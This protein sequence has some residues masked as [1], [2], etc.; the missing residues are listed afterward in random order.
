MSGT[1]V[2][3]RNILAPTD[4]SDV[5]NA[6]TAYAAHLA[7]ALKASLHVQHVIPVDTHGPALDTAQVPRLLELAERTA[8]EKL[9]ELLTEGERERLQ[10]HMVIDSGTPYDVIVEYAKQH[11]IDLIVMGTQGRGAV[12]QMWLGSVTH[13][14]LRKAHCPVLAMRASQVAA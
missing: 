3:P 7:M 1:N 8:R 9:N 13:K 2:T 11:D 5:S 14:V 6:A 4:F 12:E 10:I